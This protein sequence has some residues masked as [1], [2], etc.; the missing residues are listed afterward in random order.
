MTVEYNG[1]TMNIIKNS[2]HE[3]SRQSGRGAPVNDGISRQSRQRG[4]DSI[5]LPTAPM[6]AADVLFV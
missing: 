6:E 1:K 4:G 5:K 3:L 2:T